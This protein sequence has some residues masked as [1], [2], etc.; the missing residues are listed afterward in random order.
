MSNRDTETAYH[1]HEQTKHSYRS[2]RSDAHS[3]DFSNQPVPFKTY[4]GLKPIPLSHRW[5]ETEITAL[6][7]VSAITSPTKEE[8]IPSFSD[9]ARLL[10]YSAG[11]IKQ[12]KYPGGTLV[13]RAASC[14]GALYQVELYVVCG[15][16]PDL[17]A[18]IYHFS[19]KDFA[20]YRLREGD[21][22]AVVAQASGEEPNV[23]AAPALILSTGTYWR[24]AW[25]YRARTY[26]HF[27]WDNGTI[28]A[29]LLSMGSALQ[30]PTQLVL[31][32]VDR[33]LNQLL[34]LD[35]QREVTLSIVSLGITT[36]KATEPSPKVEVLELPTLPL[37]EREVD[38][39]EMRTLHSATSLLSEKEVALWRGETPIQ[40]LPAPEGPVWKLDPDPARAPDSIEKVIRRRGSSREFEH[41]TLSFQEFSTMLYC[42]A[43]GLS[44]DFLEPAGVLLNDW[45]L[46][47]NAVEDLPSGAYVLHREG[48]LLEL[49][50]EGDFRNQ[51]GFLGLEQR[52]P[53]D[54]SANVFFLADLEPILKQLGNRGYR[55][56]QL[57]AGILGGK[58]YLTAY[59]Q[60]L[61]ATG[62]TFYDDAVIE[63]F[64]PH[65]QGKSAIFLM[66]LGH[67]KKGL[68]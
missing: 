51:A 39:P 42:S 27:G 66:A 35:I 59:A 58:L 29:H 8:R 4:P 21:Y 60:R 7:A 45:Y 13:F 19:P 5:E 54:A 16:L 47:V 55:A 1:Y 62:L 15:D 32:F 2:V 67:G 38:Y 26:R 24:N 57:E 48:W 23:L 46:I 20:L 28:V 40:T 52:L 30:L 65:A 31:G 53:R 14:T 33:E 43:Q 6:S 50:K 11:V 25:K 68:F 56:V 12:R 17:P 63:F 44:A 3:L 18:G 61:G 64:S 49:L 34:D 41:K 22:R 37:A 9:L 10:N 36:Q